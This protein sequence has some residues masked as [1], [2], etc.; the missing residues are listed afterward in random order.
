MECL[1]SAKFPVWA[2]IQPIPTGNH[3]THSDRQSISSTPSL[4]AALCPLSIFT[5]PMGGS[6]DWSFGTLLWKICW[7]PS[8]M[9]SAKSGSPPL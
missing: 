5:G 9:A 7:E 6:S 8:S 4:L 1:S 3:P 2:G